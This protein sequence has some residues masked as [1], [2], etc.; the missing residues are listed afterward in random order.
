MHLSSV[1][2]A[3]VFVFSEAVLVIAIDRRLEYQMSVGYPD[4][5]PTHDRRPQEGTPR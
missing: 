3:L 2:V 5:Q 4:V 1:L